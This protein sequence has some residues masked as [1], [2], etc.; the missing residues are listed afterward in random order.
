MFALVLWLAFFQRT[1]LQTDLQSSTDPQAS[2]GSR[3]ARGPATS[4]ATSTRVRLQGVF[5]VAHNRMGSVLCGFG[6]R[7]RLAGVFSRVPKILRSFANAPAIPFVEQ[8]VIP[9]MRRQ[10][11]S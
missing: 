7:D 6:E 4:Y 11:R 10:R 3:V 8:F 9:P 1:I 2:S 5:G